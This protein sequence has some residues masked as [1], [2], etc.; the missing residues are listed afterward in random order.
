MGAKL[1]L[2]WIVG[3]LFLL[4]GAWI[5]QNLRLDVGV[6]DLQYV[7]AL[8]VALILFL[9]AGLAWISVAVATR[10]EFG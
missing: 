3:G 9:M 5:T 10:H 6:S 1:V 8:A 4:A 2:T 7:M